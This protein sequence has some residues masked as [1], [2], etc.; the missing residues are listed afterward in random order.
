MSEGTGKVIQVAEDISG[1]HSAA[2]TRRIWQS[3]AILLSG[4]TAS[5][6]VN[7]AAFR[8]VIKTSS[9][10]LGDQPSSFPQW[11]FQTFFTLLMPGSHPHPYW[12]TRLPGKMSRLW[13]LLP[14][15]LCSNWSISPPSIST[16]FWRMR[17]CHVQ[18]GFFCVHPD[19][20]LFSLFPDFALAIILYFRKMLSNYKKKDHL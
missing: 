10:V 15:R 8:Q 3:T 7:A 4:Q 18:G 5:L 12:Q 13:V 19:S 17:F 11:W 9:L 14:Y 6:T 1:S 20:F 2:E 16:R